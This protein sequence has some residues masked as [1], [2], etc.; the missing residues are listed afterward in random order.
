MIY[1]WFKVSRAIF[2]LLG[3]LGGVILASCHR[4]ISFDSNPPSA[5]SNCS[6]VN[7]AVG[8]T[9]VPN[10]IERLITLD[11]V[12]FENAIALGLKPVAAVEFKILENLFSN[13]LLNL[14]DL[15]S[16]NSPNLERAFQLEPDLILG[17][18]EQ[19][20]IYNQASQMAPTVL[21]P[22]EH[23][24]EWKEMF[25]FTAESLG[26]SARATEVMDAYNARLEDFKQAIDA[27][28]NSPMQNSSRKPTISVVRI[29][30]DGITLY[31]K[32]GFIGIVLQDLGLPR[33]PSQDLD[34][35]ETLLLDS[36]TI[37][38]TV[39]KESFDKADADVIFIIVGNWDDKI[40]DVLAD[41][42]ADPL[43]SKLKAVQQG[44]VYEVGDHWVG[45]G[46]IAANAVID[47]LSRY[48]LGD[49]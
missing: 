47:D 33:P 8:Q 14:A 3:I 7:H 39:S 43:W 16:Y 1:L 26:K 15:G 9:C 21:M 11:L 13:Q 18:E 2:F 35:E 45:N 24:G 38:Y 22:F 27:D 19:R 12:S 25:A 49:S 17:S 40:D 48:L 42:K 29:Y 36:S 31:T 34:L 28:V 46:P 32:V 6:L 4:D 37:Q 10:Q 44:K 23:S 30:P 20:R 5:N 41:L